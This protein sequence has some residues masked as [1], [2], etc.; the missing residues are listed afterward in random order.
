MTE[1]ANVAQMLAVAAVGLLVL[2][3]VVVG[4]SAFGDTQEGSA[5]PGCGSNLTGSLSNKTYT[6]CNAAWNVTNNAGLMTQKL[7]E[8]LPTVNFPA[9]Y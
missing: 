5:Y 3:G 8:Q 2:V 7:G 1:V 9:Q 4:L 6:R